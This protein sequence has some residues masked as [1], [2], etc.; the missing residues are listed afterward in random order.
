MNLDR[1]INSNAKILS[2]PQAVKDEIWRMRYPEEEGTKVPYDQI[3]VWLKDNHGVES[4]MG[5]LSYA[6]KRMRLER[7]WDAFADSAEQA[8]SLRAQKNPQE[9][10]EDLESFGHLVFVNETIESGDKLNFTRLR[11]V[12]QRDQELSIKKDEMAQK[13]RVIEQKD[14]IIEQNER[15]LVMLEEKER[16]LDAMENKAKELRNRGG[17]TAETLAI[18]E[19]ELNLL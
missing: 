5:G 13:D 3:L 9:A 16:R 10:L 6:F 19:K 14:K 7:R 11:K 8:K 12:R 15:R 4:S 2:L 18:L 17:L 1:E